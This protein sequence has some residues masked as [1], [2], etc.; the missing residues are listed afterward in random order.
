MN[1]L[2]QSFA[3]MPLLRRKQIEPPITDSV[4]KRIIACET[5]ADFHD[6]ALD[7]SEVLLRIE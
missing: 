2:K 5:T 1:V 3:G 6:I 4:E 7:E